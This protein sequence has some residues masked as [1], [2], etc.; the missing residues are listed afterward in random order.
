MRGDV[1]AS[2][3]FAQMQLTRFRPVRRRAGGVRFARLRRKAKHHLFSA[4][5]LPKALLPPDSI[6]LHAL[7]RKRWHLKN[8]RRC[9]YSEARWWRKRFNLSRQCST[10]R[11]GNKRSAAAD[12]I[13]SHAPLRGGTT[14]VRQASSKTLTPGDSRGSQSPWHA[15][16][17]YLSSCNERYGHRRSSV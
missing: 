10:Q 9:V 8:N 14:K 13:A 17:P 16:L 12:L 4:I 6:V 1:L 3:V 2:Y 11:Q 7:R 15:F 5:S